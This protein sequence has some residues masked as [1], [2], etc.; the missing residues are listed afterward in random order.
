MYRI[1]SPSPRSSIALTALSELYSWFGDLILR[2]DTQSAVHYVFVLAQGSLLRYRLAATT[3]STSLRRP[4]LLLANFLSRATYSLSVCFLR[5]QADGV[6]CVSRRAGVSDSLRA[7]DAAS[8]MVL[9]YNLVRR[10]QLVSSILFPP[11]IVEVKGQS[12]FCMA[13]MEQHIIS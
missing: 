7:R 9:W 12:T 4:V 10:Y 3:S 5:E 6:R 2:S 1:W 11:D 13:L 8:V